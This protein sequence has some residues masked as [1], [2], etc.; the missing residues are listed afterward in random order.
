MTE[1][2]SPLHDCITTALT[3]ALTTK[4][5]TTIPAIATHIETAVLDLYTPPFAPKGTRK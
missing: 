2:S 5:Q 3:Q 4:N 1:T